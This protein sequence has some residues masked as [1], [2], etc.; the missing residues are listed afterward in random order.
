MRRSVNGTIK[1]SLRRSLSL[2]S[3]SDAP[4]MSMAQ[5]V[6]IDPSSSAHSWITGGS[7]SRNRQ[8]TQAISDA[9]TGALKICFQENGSSLRNSRIP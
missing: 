9:Q 4:M 3:A 6:V 2:V 1:R 7:F 5:G 8:M